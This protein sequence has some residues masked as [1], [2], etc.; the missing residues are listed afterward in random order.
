MGTHYDNGPHGRSEC[1]FSY[2]ARLLG[3]GGGSGGRGYGHGRGQG[4]GRPGQIPASRATMG[5]AASML[6]PKSM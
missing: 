5:A 4:R 2:T 1:R 3:S 6:K